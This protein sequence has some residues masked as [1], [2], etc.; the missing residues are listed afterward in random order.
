M[1]RSPHLDPRLVAVVAVGGAV[2]TTRALGAHP[3]ASARSVAGGRRRRS[4]RTCSGR[5]CSGALLEALLRR[6]EESRRGRLVRLGAGTGVLGGFTTFSSLAFEMERL[7]AGGQVTMAL[8]YGALSVVLGLLAC[9]AGVAL[10]ARTTA[11]GRASRTVAMTVLLIAVARRDRRRHPVRRRRLGPHPVEPR[12]PAGHARGQRDAGRSSSACCTARTSTTGS[13]RRVAGGGRDRV[14][15]RVHHVLD[16]DG[17]DRPADPGGRA[18]PSDRERRRLGAALPRRRGARRRPDGGLSVDAGQAHAA[19]GGLVDEV[20]DGQRAGGVLLELRPAAGAAC[21]ARR[22]PASRPTGIAPNAPRI[23]AC[24][25]GR[26]RLRASRT[27]SCSAACPQ[28]HTWA[29]AG[30]GVPVEISTCCV[31][32]RISF[33]VGDRCA[34][35]RAEYR[36][37]LAA[38]TTGTKGYRPA[39]AASRAP[40]RRTSR[41][42]AA[43]PA[44][45]RRRG[46]CRA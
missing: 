31:V 11:G 7:L 32:M 26:G 39:P 37:G 21:G 41:R 46:R 36:S 43:R 40:G 15:R 35:R 42:G 23:A 4:S 24:R 13:V 17:G 10:A 19:L 3:V 6:G 25:T 30:A 38:G 14:L 9:V 16:R 29:S 22:A 33:E 8:L 28:L 27:I 20:L 45:S 5:S 18:A 34:G 44:G 1:T 12:V 2:G